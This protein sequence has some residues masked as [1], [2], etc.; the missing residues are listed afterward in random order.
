MTAVKWGP[1]VNETMNREK[2]RKL[3][4]ISFDRGDLCFYF[5]FLNRLEA[6]F[7][8]DRIG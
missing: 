6:E 1:P 3:K 7:E 8:K 4:K 5:T 2:I